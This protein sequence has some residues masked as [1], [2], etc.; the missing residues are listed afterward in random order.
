MTKQEINSRL[1]ERETNVHRWSLAHGY[2]PR[3]V[4]QV[5]DRWAGRQDAPLGRLSYR[6]MQ[7]LS[8]EI[9]SEIIPGI[10]KDAA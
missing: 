3:T 8:R 10:L 1:I 9:G 2:K 6:I 4:G 5:V 7:D